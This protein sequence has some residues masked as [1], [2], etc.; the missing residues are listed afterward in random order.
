MNSLYPQVQS[1]YINNLNHKQQTLYNTIGLSRSS[2]YTIRISCHA[3]RSLVGCTPY[4]L[5]LYT[6]QEVVERPPASL[7]ASLLSVPT[8]IS[9]DLG[10]VM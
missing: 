6:F 10:H 9:K 2:K 4:I 7:P 3:S 5:S 8:V 1:T